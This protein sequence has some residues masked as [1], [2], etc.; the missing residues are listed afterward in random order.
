MS[1][2]GEF[3]RG[4][5]TLFG[6]LHGIVSIPLTPESDHVVIR[7]GNLS[8]LAAA[9][10]PVLFSI[11]EAPERTDLWSSSILPSDRYP[12]R[13]GEARPD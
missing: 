13:Q 6:Q 9:S 1:G 10:A 2:A 7:R 11:F 3:V 5:L 4:S 8:A 12:A